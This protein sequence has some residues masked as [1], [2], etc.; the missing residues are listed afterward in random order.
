MLTTAKSLPLPVLDLLN[1][2]RSVVI[3]AR[4]KEKEKILKCLSSDR[5]TKSKNK[6]KSVIVSA[7]TDP[8]VP[9]EE[10]TIDLLLDEGQ[11]ITFA[12]VDTTA[13]ALSV[14]MFHLLNDKVKVTGILK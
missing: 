4:N 5:E 9:A 1:P 7:L 6:S 11:T 13:R 8:G 12:G 10:K 2:N 14:A 3:S